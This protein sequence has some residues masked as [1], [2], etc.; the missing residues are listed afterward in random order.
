MGCSHPIETGQVYAIFTW[1]I[2]PHSR[3]PRF[4]CEE[5]PT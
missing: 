4:T 3:A 5:H 1:A 2:A